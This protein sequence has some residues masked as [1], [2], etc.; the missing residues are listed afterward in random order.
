MITY[1]EFLKRLRKVKSKGYVKTH[2]SGPTGIGKTIEDLLGVKE[3]NAPGPDGRRIELKSKRKN[4]S[5]MVTLFTKSPLP[6]K[7]NSVL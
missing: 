3:N 1:S 6:P 2:R 5:N 7:V 4:A